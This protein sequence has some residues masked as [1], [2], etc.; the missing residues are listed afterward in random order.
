[1]LFRGHV[2][3]DLAAWLA[4]QSAQSCAS[5]HSLMNPSMGF[6]AVNTT[7]VLFVQSAAGT[8]YQ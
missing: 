2:S 5:L 8:P 3:N 7:S 6:A 1:M 4:Q